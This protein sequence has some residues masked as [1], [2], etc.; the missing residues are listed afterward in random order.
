[1]WKSSFFSQ[2]LTKNSQVENFE[3]LKLKIQYKNET[4]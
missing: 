1:M 4:L 3:K 2:L